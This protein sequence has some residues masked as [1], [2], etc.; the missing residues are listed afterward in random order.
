MFF[1]RKCASSVAARVLVLLHA[2]A[3]RRV[4]HEVLGAA[5][6]VALPLAVARALAEAP[7]AGAQLDHL[8]LLADHLGAGAA[9]GGAAVVVV[10]VADRPVAAVH[11]FLNV[12]KKH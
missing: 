8:A 10:L 12:K 11:V 7:L 1:L 2:C 6:L 9:G 5:Q 3:L 4:P